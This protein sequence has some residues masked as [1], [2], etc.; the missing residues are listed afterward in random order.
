M[1]SFN[2]QRICLLVMTLCALAAA[3]KPLW[4]GLKLVR[5]PAKIRVVEIWVI[6][7][8]DVPLS[9]AEMKDA[10]AQLLIAGFR[11]EALTAANIESCARWVRKTKRAQEAALRERKEKELAYAESLASR[12]RSL[13]G[14]GIALA[15]GW[16]LVVALIWGRV[17]PI[18][19]DRSSVNGDR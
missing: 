12:G 14:L 8:D 16:M 1:R 2:F 19:S 11:K 9:P 3:A 13:I 6:P 18:P 17:G 10:E 4:V 15:V 5:E 7:P